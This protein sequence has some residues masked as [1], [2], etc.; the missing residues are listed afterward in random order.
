MYEG[1]GT[2]EVANELGVSK[3]LALL[4]VPRRL[5][6]EPFSPTAQTHLCSP[7]AQFSPFTVSFMPENVKEV[8]GM[9]LMATFC[10]RG[11]K[12][13]EYEK[14][15]SGHKGNIKLSNNESISITS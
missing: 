1:A 3:F 11:D 12:F 2:E 15:S 9:A 6:T 13:R 7:S 4:W 5:S 14:C 8:L 10:N